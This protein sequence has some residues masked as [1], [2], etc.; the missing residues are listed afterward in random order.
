MKNNSDIR[1]SQNPQKIE[2]PLETIDVKEIKIGNTRVQLT[3]EIITEILRDRYHNH[4]KLTDIKA[5]YHIGH[6]TYK[7]INKFAG[8]FIERFGKKDKKITIGEMENYW[9]SIDSQELI[10]NTS[11]EADIFKEV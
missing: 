9:N 7:E 10:N 1:S 11:P 3:P 8:K 6:Q 4:M 2:D 5:K